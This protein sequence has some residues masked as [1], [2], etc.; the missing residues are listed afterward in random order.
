MRFYSFKYA[1]VL[2]ISLLVNSIW[3]DSLALFQKPVTLSLAASWSANKTIDNWNSDAERVD[4]R[5]LNLLR[6][7]FG[8]ERHYRYQ[9]TDEMYIA[10][11]HDVHVFKDTRLNIEYA[12]V[13]KASFLNRNYEQV[14]VL[15]VRNHKVISFAYKRSDYKISTN[16]QFNLNLEYYTKSPLFFNSGLTYVFSDKNISGFS[17][18]FGANADISPLMLFS[19]FSLGEELNNES[20]PP[21][22]I[23]YREVSVRSKY[24]LNDKINC[25]Y[26]LSLYQNNLNHQRLNNDIMLGFIF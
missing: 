25:S 14:S 11:L 17:Y 15:H 7:S 9:T 4:F 5:L 22:R 1:I 6:A 13:P 26:G 19:V 3:A 23:Y 12:N 24:M 2:L 20:N 8:R 18:L 21:S 10:G 16:Q